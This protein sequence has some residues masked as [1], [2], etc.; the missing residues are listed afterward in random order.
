MINYCKATTEEV[1]MAEIPEKHE[2]SKATQKETEKATMSS[3]EAAKAKVEEDIAAAE[4]A[5]AVSA[6][7]VTQFVDYIYWIIMALIVVRFTFKLIGANAEN[8][9][10]KL[11][12]SVSDPFVNLFK[13]IVGD[14]T[15]SGSSVIEIS[16][17]IAL[18]IIWLLYH[19]ILKLIVVLR[20]K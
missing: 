5:R 10:V 15:T 12:Y 8:A 3:T 17:L 13:G 16:S 19:A 14:I 9:L 11:L 1:I 6:I 20:S 4:E 18:L 2:E 7:K